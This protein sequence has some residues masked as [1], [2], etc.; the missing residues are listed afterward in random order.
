MAARIVN[1]GLV[2][3]YRVLTP[4]D[5]FGKGF[6]DPLE[7]AGRLRA[8]AI[9]VQIGYQGTDRVLRFHASRVYPYVDLAA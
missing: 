4:T 7:R 9:I 6:G 5:Y 3:P 8:F 2:T 1:A